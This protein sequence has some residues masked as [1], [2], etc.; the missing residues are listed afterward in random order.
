M[1]FH[2]DLAR[3]FWQLAVTYS[4]GCCH[5]QSPRTHHCHLHHPQ[6][7]EHLHIKNNQVFKPA[8]LVFYRQIN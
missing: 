1:I 7:K 3:A 2:V 5:S 6:R 8:Y 4:S